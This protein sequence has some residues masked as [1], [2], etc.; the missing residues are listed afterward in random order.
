MSFEWIESD[1]LVESVHGLVHLFFLV[2]TFYTELMTGKQQLCQW[3]QKSRWV[4]FAEMSRCIRQHSFCTVR[5]WSGAVEM[6]EADSVSPI[7][8][9]NRKGLF[10]IVSTPLLFNF[11]SRFKRPYFW[12]L[13]QFEYMYQNAQMPWTDVLIKQCVKSAYKAVC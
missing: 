3:K 13:L 11:S 7:L 4:S 12:S 6:W 5:G 8:L 10:C 9:P 2:I 1:G